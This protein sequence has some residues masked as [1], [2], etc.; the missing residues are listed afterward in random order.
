MYLFFEHR[1]HIIGYALEIGLI[2]LV[3]LCPLM[4]IFMHHGHKHK[5][6][7]CHK[8]DRQHGGKDATD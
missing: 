3:L 2:I 4:H 7:K 5:D 8:K 6:D 1:A